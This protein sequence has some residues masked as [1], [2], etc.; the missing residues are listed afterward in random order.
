MHKDLLVSG[1]NVRARVLIANA[2]FWMMSLA[3]LA[4]VSI[5][6][7]GCGSDEEFTYELSE[8]VNTSSCTT[9]KQ[10]FDS[11]EDYCKGL[12]DPAR[13]YNC[14]E[15]QRKTLYKQNCGNNWT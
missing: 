6:L 3:L 11:K 4:T 5:L 14:A 1:K 12:Q 7:S 2:T 15:G 8:T 9:K 10:E 13:N